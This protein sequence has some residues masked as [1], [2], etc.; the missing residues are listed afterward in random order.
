[1]SELLTEDTCRFVETTESFPPILG[2]SGL[3]D[4]LIVTLDGRYDLM[5]SD[6]WLLL[7]RIGE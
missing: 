4:D 7:E 2:M 3:L 1:M 6:G 5:A